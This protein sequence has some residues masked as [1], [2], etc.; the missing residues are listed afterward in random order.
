MIKL[1]RYVISWFTELCA[2]CGVCA[3]STWPWSLL[4]L[5]TMVPALPCWCGPGDACS[6]QACGGDSYFTF[7]GFGGGSG[8]GGWRGVLLMPATVLKVSF[9]PQPSIRY[10]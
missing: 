2:E 7:E 10:Y 9:V 1:N 5:A 4:A 3:F 8:G 6:I